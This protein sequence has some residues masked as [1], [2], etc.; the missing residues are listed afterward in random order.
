MLFQNFLKTMG[1]ILKYFFNNLFF[2]LNT[3]DRSNVKSYLKEFPYV[4]GNLFDGKITLPNFFKGNSK[5][6]Y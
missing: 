3:K 4:N 6:D 2:I 1:Q 5:N